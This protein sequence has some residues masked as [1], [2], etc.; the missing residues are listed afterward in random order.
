MGKISNCPVIFNIHYTPYK[1]KK[2]LPKW[3]VIKHAKERAFYDLTGEYNIYKY[4]TTEHKITGDGSTGYTMLEYLQK[5]TGVFN[6]NGMISK[7]EVKVMKERLRNNKGNIWHGFISFDEEN[8]HKIDHPDKCIELI[9]RNFGQF[10]KDAQMDEENI[11]LM[12]SL[13]L[14]TEHHLH[15]HFCFWEKEPKI[16]NQRAAGYKYRAKGKI[17]MPVIEKMVERLT[18]FTITDEKL[19]FAMNE[20]ISK[21]K[22]RDTYRTLLYEDLFKHDILRLA[23]EIPDNKYY[24]H[25]EMQPYRERID[26]IVSRLIYKDKEMTKYDETFR[27]I[28]SESKT[29]MQR[30]M[31]EYYKTRLKKEQSKEYEPSIELKEIHCIETLEYDYKRR[32]G[33]ILIHKLHAIKQAD[34]KR[35]KNKT[36]FLNDKRLKAKMDVSR[37]KIKGLL[38][39]LLLTFARMIEPEISPRYNR[40]KEIEEEMIEEKARENREAYLEEI[41]KAERQKYNRYNYG[42]G[43]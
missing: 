16:K 2:G 4:M 6:K 17:Q 9:K 27:K 20:T 10:F 24:G 35:D 31:G 37:R 30:Y 25:K 22:D 7:E 33:N 43:D 21:L 26:K 1:P 12:C 36:Y 5:C 3:S 13:H 15:I 40:L 34:F 39:N 32:L 41:T 23:K 18:F 8:S 38:G 14:D 29:E 28:L 42:K 19:R 11:D